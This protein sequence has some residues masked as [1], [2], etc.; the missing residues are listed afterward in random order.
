MSDI[1]KGAECMRAAVGNKLHGIGNPK[2]ADI[3]TWYQNQDYDEIHTALNKQ[4][5]LQRGHWLEIGVQNS[6]SANGA[7][8]LP[9]LE[10][11]V[12]LDD[13]TRHLIN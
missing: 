2:P 11:D 3:V 6:L 10:I 13:G 9:Q 4:L 5:V 8:Y 7:S 12:V 1:G